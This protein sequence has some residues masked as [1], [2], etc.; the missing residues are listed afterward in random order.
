LNIAVKTTVK[1][2]GN[3]EDSELEKIVDELSGV[4]KNI[5][6][7]EILD[8]ITYT[9]FINMLKNFY[10]GCLTFGNFIT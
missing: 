2:A 1:S 3:I 9:T 7:N 6:S 10:S 4:V 5:K 8:D